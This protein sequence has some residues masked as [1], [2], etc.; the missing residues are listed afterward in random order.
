MNWNKSNKI[1]LSM[2]LNFVYDIYDILL[3]GLFDGILCWRKHEHLFQSA[4]FIVCE[5]ERGSKHLLHLKQMHS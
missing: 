4:L 3:E 1:L 5:W 2:E